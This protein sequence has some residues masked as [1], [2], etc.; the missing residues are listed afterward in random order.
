MA[1]SAEQTVCVHELG[2]EDRGAGGAANRVVSESHELV[3]EHRTHADATDPRPGGG[4]GLEATAP[5]ARG[6]AFSSYTRT[7]LLAM[8]DVQRTPRHFVTA[9][10]VPGVSWANTFTAL[11][12]LLVGFFVHQVRSDNSIA[13]LSFW[14]W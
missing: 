2:V 1:E 9:T 6:A 13:A 10:G 8:H 12:R 14:I 4:T 11:S 3:R 5:P 7:T